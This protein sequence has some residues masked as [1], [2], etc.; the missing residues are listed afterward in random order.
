MTPRLTSIME[1]ATPLGASS[2]LSIELNTTDSW[3]TI[4]QKENRP[5]MASCVFVSAAWLTP[6][7]MT[8]TGGMAV[9]IQ[10][11]VPH[12]EATTK[13]TLLMRLVGRSMS[14]FST[15]MMKWL[16]TLVPKNDLWTGCVPNN[17]TFIMRYYMKVIHRGQTNPWL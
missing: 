2:N 8:S 12:L 13:S 4:S 9:S 11:C 15:L 16:K 14:Y 17:T 10:Q 6:K 1:S 3:P 5:E 7:I